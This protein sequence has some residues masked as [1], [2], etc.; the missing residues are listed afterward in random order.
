VARVVAKQQRRRRPAPRA[1]DSRPA[2]PDQQT[3]MGVKIYRRLNDPGGDRRGPNAVSSVRRSRSVGLRIAS[4]ARRI[5]P[6]RR[7]KSSRAPRAG[8][9]VEKLPPA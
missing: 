4:A 3:A 7:R 5:A 6:D 8:V 9:S 1:G 2:A